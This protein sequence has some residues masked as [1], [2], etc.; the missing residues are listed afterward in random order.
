MEQVLL[1]N[2]GWCD[3]LRVYK[4]HYKKIDRLDC[5]QHICFLTQC[6]WDELKN[7]PVY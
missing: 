7:T 4:Y 5:N 3:L 2:L 1:A 6:M